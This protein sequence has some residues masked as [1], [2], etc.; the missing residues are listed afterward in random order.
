MFKELI[1]K[2]KERT[3]RLVNLAKWLSRQTYNLEH[4]I[5][6]TYTLVY[7]EF[8]VH[9]PNPRLT[10]INSLFELNR[11]VYNIMDW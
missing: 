8:E 3:D 9:R 6:E 4:Q 10:K 1:T 5:Y 2:V 11:I 7:L